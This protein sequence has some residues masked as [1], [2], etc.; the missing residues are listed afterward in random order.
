[1]NQNDQIKIN[2]PHIVAV[3]D[4]ATSL[5]QIREALGNIH[6]DC[7]SFQ[8]PHTALAAMMAAPPDVLITDVFMPGLDGFQLAAL[9]RQR[10]PTTLIIG[11]S[12][13]LDSGC[14]L[15]CSALRDRL[16][17]DFLFAKPLD[18]LALFAALACALRS[19]TRPDRDWNR[20][21]QAYPYPMR[22]EACPKAANLAV[23]APSA[24]T[25][26]QQREPA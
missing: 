4:Q 23:S 12:G 25:V 5:Q 18:P 19:L 21:R 22:T 17:A 24:T 1:M 3:D 7:R 11:V 16:G 15:D 8:N 9:T 14:G 20:S 6:L 13:A 2:R 10:C 26:R